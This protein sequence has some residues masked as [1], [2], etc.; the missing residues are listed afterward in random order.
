MPFFLNPFAFTALAAIPILIGIYYLRN[1]FKRRV[2][3]SLMLW[4]G[5]IKGNE[6]GQKKDRLQL[7]WMFFLELF[8]LLA[9]AFAATQPFVKT[10][11]SRIPA[12]IVLDDSYS[13]LATPTGNSNRSGADDQTG[14]S[15][16]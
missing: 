5:I 11:S 1:R 10:S 6:G 9:L 2:V 12:T 16:L 8:G 3:S 4:D 14:V 15:D 13:M 7:P